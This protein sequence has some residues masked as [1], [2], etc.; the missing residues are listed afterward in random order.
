[1]ITQSL[2]PYNINMT[3]RETAL[4]ILDT[5]GYLSKSI[6]ARSLKCSLKQ[7]GEVLGRLENMENVEFRYSRMN[8]RS[9]EI[10]KQ[11]LEGCQIFAISRL[12]DPSD[13]FRAE[14]GLKEQFYS[15]PDLVY[16]PADSGIFPQAKRESVFFQVGQQ[17]ST[18]KASGRRQSPPSI[19]VDRGNIEICGVSNHKDGESVLRSEK[20]S[21][22]KEPRESGESKVRFEV[23]ENTPA[24]EIKLKRKATP[25]PK[26][27]KKVVRGKVTVGKAEKKVKPVEEYF[28]PTLPVVMKRKVLKTRHYVE[29]GKLVTEDYSSEEDFVVNTTP[30]PLVQKKTQSKLEFKPLQT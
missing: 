17:S 6:L 8:G 7:A 19:S 29:S 28:V 9:I 4:K 2:A 18:V 12:K 30:M 14:V 23:D 24:H 16:P 13:I 21:I 22:K 26:K 20:N 27:E 11:K 5:A 25:F 10:F 1:L 15:G 3:E